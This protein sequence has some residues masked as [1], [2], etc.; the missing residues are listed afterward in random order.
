MTKQCWLTKLADTL[1]MLEARDSL[2]LKQQSMMQMSA[3]KM[4]QIAPM[5]ILMGLFWRR[6]VPESTELGFIVI[7]KTPKAMRTPATINTSK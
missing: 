5:I 6:V 1:R 4:R 7:R 2:F 3:A